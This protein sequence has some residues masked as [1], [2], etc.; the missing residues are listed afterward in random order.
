MLEVVFGTSLRRRNVNSA[1]TLV[2]K[3]LC[4]DLVLGCDSKLVE[5]WAEFGDV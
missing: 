4:P 5:S 2:Q 1:P 3:L